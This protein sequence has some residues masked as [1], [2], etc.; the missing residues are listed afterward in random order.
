MHW[1]TGPTRKPSA[2]GPNGPTSAPPS[3]SGDNGEA[4]HWLR[5]HDFPEQDDL[6]ILRRV[7]TRDGRSRAYINGQ[8]TTLAELKTLGEMLI[9]IHSQHEHQSLLK[10]ATHQRLLDAF[11]TLQDA[12]RKVQDLAARARKLQQEITTLK[13][14]S[15][16]QAAQIELLGFQV[17][18]STNCACRPTNSP[19]SKP[20]TSN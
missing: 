17:K 5:D 15:A 7:L 8:S 13:T 18:S 3:P 11:G 1:G 19:R 2:A 10:T 16:T 9:D 14:A 6:C 4:L 12:A 20:N